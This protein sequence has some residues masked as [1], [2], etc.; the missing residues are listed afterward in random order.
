MNPLTALWN[1]FHGKRACL[2]RRSA[3]TTVLTV[4]ALEERLVLSSAPVGPF[5]YSDWQSQRFSIEQMSVANPPAVTSQ[6]AQTQSSV[7]GE[8]FGADIN[9]PQVVAN[10]PYRGDGYSVAIIDTGIDYNNPALGGGWG[11]RVIAGYNFV[12][13]TSDP[14]DDNG[15]GTHVAGIIGSS[16]ATYTG[17]APDCNFVALKVLD[18]SG[19]GSFG[20]VDQALQW[21]AAHQ[22]Q[23][24][25]VAVNMSLGS[26]NYTSNPYTFLEGDFASLK[27]EGVFVAVASG[28]SF[29]SV[30]SQ[31]GLAYPAI[32][33]QVV[34]VGAVWDGNFGAVSWVSGARDNTTAQDDIASFTQRS[35]ALSIMAPG[36]MIT[37]T[38]L[39][40]SFKQ[41]AG[42]SMATPVVA[43]S[44][45]LIHQAL[46]ARG[47]TGQVSQDAILKLMQST[48][49]TIIDS[50]AA[51]ANVT[52]TGLT[53][54][55]LDLYAAI[56]G[57]RPAVNTPP[58]LGTIANQTMTAGIPLTVTLPASD[59]DGDP[60]TFAGKAKG[61]G[62]SQVYQYG[63]TLGL[64]YGGSYFQNSIGQNEKWILG[65]NSQWYCLMPNGDLR[66]WLGNATD[67]LTAA[68]LVNNLTAAVYNDPTQLWTAPATADV[69]VTCTFAGTQLTV[70][71]DPSFIGSFSLTVTASD[72]RASTSQSFTVSVTNRAPVLGAIANQTMVHA[73]KAKVISLVAT[74]ADNDPLTFTAQALAPS[75]QAYKLQQS[76]G[77]SYTGNYWTNY[78]GQQERWLQGGD[79]WYCLLPNGELRRAGNS[80]FDML[81]SASLV[82]TLDSSFYQNPSLLW[83]A[84]APVTPAVTIAFNAN[85]MTVTPAASVVG[86][87]PVRITVSDGKVSVNQTFS[88]TVTDT[89]PVLGAIPNQTMTHGK[90]L[91]V[92][93]NASD[94]DGDVLTP[95]ATTVVPSRQALN[96][97]QALGLTYGGN[98]WTNYYGQNEKWLQGTTGWYCV[99]PNGE[100]RQSGSSAAQMLAAG[101]LVATLDANYSLDP[102]LLWNAAHYTA[103]QV[104]YAVAG[105]QLT[106]TPATSFV[107]TFLVNVSAGDGAATVQQTFSV[108]TTNTAPV[109]A[110]VANQTLSHSQGSLTVTLSATD[111]EGDALTYSAQALSAGQMAYNL[112][113]TLGLTYTGNYWTGYYGAQE[114]WLKG[115][116]GQW[117]ALLPNG[118]LRRTGNS[119]TDMLAPGAVIA[120]L[121]SSFY[122]DPS[123]LWNAQPGTAIPVTTTVT[124]NQLTIQPAAGYLGTFTVQVSVSDGVTTSQRSFTVNVANNAP[125][126][127]NLVNQVQSL[128]QVQT[129][130]ALVFTV[131]VSDADNDHVTLTAQAVAFNQPAYNLQRQY[132]FVFTGDYATGVWGA[133][134][135]WLKGKDG[136][137]Y[138]ILP[139]GEVRQGRASM[140]ATLQSDALIA[141]LDPA[142]YNDPSLLW[143]AQAPVAPR[144]TVIVQGNQLTVTP[145]NGFK[146]TFYVEVT[147][148]DGYTS[149]TRDYL[150]TV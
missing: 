96:L 66:K 67:T 54:K 29:Y 102:S 112:K 136:N 16:D 143:N 57:A 140:A 93:L 104:T 44:A 18:A 7:V 135:K 14:M 40:D 43:G 73:L 120:T 20:A 82:A 6:T 31:Q 150:V 84:H 71:C 130:S 45:L 13:N 148:S 17:I 106:I 88:F 124:G 1:M 99:L 12:N 137:W 26:G 108:T 30:N 58:T 23:Y 77:L 91:V 107:G 75:D 127:G 122:Q 28:N 34:S 133:S 65:A 46:D 32:S 101:S 56:N 128:S 22:A 78:Y 2:R 74:D 11:K 61:N 123:L 27:S 53:F 125:G 69:P 33:P 94:A 10:Y 5:N 24:N 3:A 141:T 105:N 19:S 80:A 49:A 76:L 113:Q 129:Q 4:E 25:I 39:N 115:Q 50:D 72:G 90:S 103:P 83:N 134:E 149:T 110:P 8:G 15:H 119:A 79:G 81:A 145:V 118:E 70:Q 63:Q 38:Y 37:S 117:Y 62:S 147:A 59:A 86:T 109:L 41:M 89:P 95:V 116:D 47:Q 132:G 87:F 92:N 97:A 142:F 68:A 138:C 121:D 35:S 21:V 60:L 111:A 42:T 48:G 146:G 139:N 64:S 131:P 114:K 36:A 52:N 9:L 51:H 126:L 98:Y 55:R 100:L 85:Q 144:V